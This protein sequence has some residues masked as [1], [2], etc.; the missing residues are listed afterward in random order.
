MLA[1]YKKLSI[2]G[3]IT[4]FFFAP[5]FHAHAQSGGS[6]T[7][8]TGTVV[9]PTG[10]VVAN[11]VVEIHNPVSAFERTVTTDSLGKFNIPNVPFN[12][13]HLTVTGPDFAPYAQDVDVRSIVPV[14]VSITLQIKGSSETV[15]VEGAGA[16][17]LENTSTFHTDVDRGLFDKMPLESRSSSVSS[18]VTLSS[19]G[20]AADSNGLFHGLGD[21]AENSFSVDGQPITDQQSKVFSNQIPLD[22]IESMEVISGA[23]PAEFGEK[24]SVVINVTT[25][26]GQGMTSPKGSI[27]SSYGS[28]GTADLGINLGYGGQKWG[29]FISASGLNSGRFL[30]PPEFTVFHDKG[31]EENLFD[32]VDFQVSKVDSVHVN[33]GFT[34][35]WFQTPNAFDNLNTGVTDPV[36]GNPVAPTDQ[37]SQIKTFNIAP[38]WTRLLSPN[39]VFTL[40]AFVRRDQYNY[41]PSANPFSDLG[42]IQQESVTQN[43]MLANTGVRSDVSYVKGIHNLKAG[44]TYQQTFLDE[45]TRFGIVDASLNAPCFD[46]NGNAVPWVGSPG[47]NDPANCG[48]AV[49]TNPGLYPAP[50]TA[51]ANFFNSL[52]CFDLTRP[53]PATADGCAGSAPSSGLFR[54]NGHADIKQLAL[55]VQD[56]ITK[57]AWSLNL[58]LRGDI[59][60]GLTT[61]REAEPRLGVA[62]NVKKTNTILRLSYARVLETPFNENLVLAS[63]GCDTLVLASLLGCATPGVATPFAPGW[64][65]EFHAGLQ[66][67]FGKYVVFS[68]EYIWKYTHNA[69]D[70]SVLGS[71][72]ITFPIE[73]HNS[74]IPGFAGRVSV[75][76]FHGVSALMVF[77]SVTARFFTP[78]IGGAGAVPAGTLGEAFTAFR[79]DHDERFNQTTHVQYQPWKAGPWVGFNWRYDSGLVAGSVPVADASGTVDLSGLTGDQQL[80]A[81]LFCGSAR[82]TLTTPLGVCT[83]VYGSTL[84]S[85]P[86]PGKEN[87]DTNPPRIAPRNLF[88]LA[89]GDDNL[90]H[91]ERY[92][93]SLT[94]T[95][96]NLT[97]RVAL[98]NF[99]STFSGTH[100][101]TPRA[102]TA[103]IGFHF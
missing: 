98:Y 11:A 29:N 12:P 91:G 75:P 9:D 8:V 78:Q 76:N 17:L 99:L 103:E 40:G 3:F 71:T 26:S 64:R 94:L 7:S 22:S 53:A 70:F 35:S 41:Y 66:Q 72:P 37:R 24:T 10:A 84:I 97:N 51:N 95:A 80:Q 16:D 86:A 36:V 23:P 46:A 43:R 25:R 28:F 60:N 61:H 101:V 52:G 82:P 48:S 56:T 13:Y 27:T 20:I 62:Y 73:W 87:D 30:D 33:L 81:G 93:W 45:D 92:K 58:G 42:S 100:F 49:S 15:T 54:F 50:F 4:V 18:L 96:I 89:V 2:A 74:K 34:R 88:D 47:L 90:F 55:Y 5:G 67:A 85:L 31:N 77:S 21:H 102:L 68:G 57:G 1:F 44:A 63:T 83:A 79:I 69:Y 59:Y 19:P 14:N 32:R 6:S 38:S 65:N 39:A